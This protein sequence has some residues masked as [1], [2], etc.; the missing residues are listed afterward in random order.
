MCSTFA[1]VGMCVCLREI[2]FMQW[3]Y[4]C[5]IMGVRATLVCLLSLDMSLTPS[6]SLILWLLVQELPLLYSGR[7]D[8]LDACVGSLIMAEVSE[9]RLNETLLRGSLWSPQQRSNLLQWLCCIICATQI[10]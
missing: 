4:D 9:G 3:L 6:S 10:L 5:D 2:V 1:F 7:I 8:F